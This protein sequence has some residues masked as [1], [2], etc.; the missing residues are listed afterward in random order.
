MCLARLCPRRCSAHGLL[1][2]TLPCSCRPES[3]QLA[4]DPHQCSRAEAPGAV[5]PWL[6]FQQPALSTTLGAR[7]W[8]LRALLNLVEGSSRKYSALFRFRLTAWVH[9]SSGGGGQLPLPTPSLL[10]GPPR[11]VNVP[12]PSCRDER[13]CPGWWRSLWEQNRWCLVL[14]RAPG[15]PRRSVSCLKLYFCCRQETE[16]QEVAGREFLVSFFTHSLSAVWE[17]S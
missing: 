5:V 11:L 16:Q 8:A 3:S 13:C 2:P 10:G 1:I 14:W 7:A 15:W 4:P 17:E 12:H 6:A 9:R